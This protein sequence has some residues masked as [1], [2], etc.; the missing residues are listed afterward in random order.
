MC[1]AIAQIFKHC[2]KC[3]SISLVFVSFMH[4][5]ALFCK[6]VPGLQQPV[7]GVPWGKNG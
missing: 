6:G 4:L 5:K 3:I 1:I 7:Q 2:V